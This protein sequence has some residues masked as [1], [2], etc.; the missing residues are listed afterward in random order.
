[1]SAVRFAACLLVEHCAARVRVSDRGAIGRARCAGVFRL[2]GSRSVHGGAGPPARS[3]CCWVGGLGHRRRHVIGARRGSGPSRPPPPRSSTIL[4]IS[5]TPDAPRNVR[6]PTDVD[7]PDRPKRRTAEGVGSVGSL[8]Q[9]LA[10]PR[11]DPSR[12]RPTAR[13]QRPN[14]AARAKRRLKR[15]LAQR[16]MRVALSVFHR[17]GRPVGSMSNQ[18]LPACLCCKGQVPSLRR[19]PASTSSASRYRSSPGEPVFAKWS[20]PRRMS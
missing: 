2:H 13:W 3:T 6:A 9:A 20:S 11:P 14:D 16:R 10:A 4:M 5:A 7:T 8:L 17:L 1:M 18:T 12:Y 15:R 19:R